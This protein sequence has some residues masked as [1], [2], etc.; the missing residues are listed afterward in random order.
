MQDGRW[1]DA[2]VVSPSHNL[3]KRNKNLPLKPQEEPAFFRWPQEPAGSA[4][5]DFQEQ[6]KLVAQFNGPKQARFTHQQGEEAD[7]CPGR[8]TGYGPR[9]PHHRTSVH[10]SGSS[11]QLRSE[12]KSLS[13]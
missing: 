8:S 1:L 12:T 6:N 13:R 10:Q 9:L 7:P 2:C 4:A 11:Q 5:H 3:Q